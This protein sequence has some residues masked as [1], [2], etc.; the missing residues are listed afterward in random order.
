MSIMSTAAAADY[1]ISDAF[2]HI[3]MKWDVV[4]HI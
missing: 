3:T 2:V 4:R 1:R